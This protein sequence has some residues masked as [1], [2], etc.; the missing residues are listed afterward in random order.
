M[1]TPLQDLL[2]EHLTEFYLHADDTPAVKKLKLQCMVRL[3]K[4]EN[5]GDL[6]NELQVSVYLPSLR[7]GS[8]SLSRPIFVTQTR[9]RL[10]RLS[11][12]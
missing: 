12:Q 5:V 1:D 10:P 6:L 4:Q 3:A 11:K 7:L 2:S 9:L 8:H